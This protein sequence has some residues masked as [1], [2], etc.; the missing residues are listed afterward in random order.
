MLTAASCV[1]DVNSGEAVEPSNITV[2]VGGETIPVAF[3][4]I[5]DCELGSD[6]LS[7]SCG[8]QLMRGKLL[9]SAATPPDGR[10]AQHALP[11]LPTPLPL[12]RRPGS[13]DI[14]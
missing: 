2:W 10:A 3:L 6:T 1:W 12:P 8:Q 4:N 11:L 13:L 9:R 7:H 14:V 5:S